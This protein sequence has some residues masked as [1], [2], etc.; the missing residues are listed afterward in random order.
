MDMLETVT[1]VVLLGA[2]AIAINIV[3]MCALFEMWSDK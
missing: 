3:I 2:G 1:T